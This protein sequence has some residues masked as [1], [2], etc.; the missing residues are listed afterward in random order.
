MTTSTE[1]T[2]PM[3]LEEGNQICPKCRGVG[4]IWYNKRRRMGYRVFC[5]KC[6]GT[7][8]LDWV[9]LLMGKKLKN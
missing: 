2:N 4:R 7:G 1:T 8:K 9:E 5:P 3:N 6:K